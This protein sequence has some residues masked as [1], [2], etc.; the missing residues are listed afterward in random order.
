M[1]LRKDQV[2]ALS[3][4]ILDHLRAKALIEIKAE[5]DAVLNRIEGVIIQNLEAEDLLDQEVEKIL[6]KGSAPKSGK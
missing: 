2:H 6:P 3:K 1:R 4:I 5:A